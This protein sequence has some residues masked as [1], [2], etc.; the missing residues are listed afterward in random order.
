MQPDFQS[1]AC[2]AVA[3]MLLAALSACHSS[4]PSGAYEPLP[5]SFRFPAPKGELEGLIS[6]RNHPLLRKHLAGVCRHQRARRA[7]GP[8]FSEAAAAALG[9]LVSSAG[10]FRR[11]APHRAG[12][13]SARFTSAGRT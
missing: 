7:D 12:P 4:P 13:F 9:N 10:R 2:A 11:G 6:C 1:R 5:S 8:A 3:C